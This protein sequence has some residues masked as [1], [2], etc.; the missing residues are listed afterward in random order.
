[1]NVVPEDFLTGFSS[2]SILDFFMGLL[3]MG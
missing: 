3:K 1:M 2:P